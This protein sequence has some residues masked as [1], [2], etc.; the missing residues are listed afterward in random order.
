V[1]PGALDRR[2]PLIGGALA[3]LLALAWQSF[4]VHYNYGGNWT[5][6]FCTGGNLVQPPALDAEHIYRFAGS[7]GYDSQFYHYV[8]HD[9]LF[10]E[11][12]DRYIDAPRLR[13]RRILTPGLAY[14]AAGGQAG[15]IDAALVAVNL[16]FLFAG[17]EWS[18]R[19]AIEAHQ[20][21]AWGL[22]FLL[23]PAALISLDRLTV[24]LALT[25]LSVAF[26]LYVK[27]ERS[28][29]IYVVLLLAALTRETGLLLTAAYCASLLL[30]RRISRALLFA[31]SAAPALGWY[32]FVY[33]HTAAY[34]AEGWFT[35]VPLGA[36]VERMIHPAA[37]PFIPAVAWAAGI[38]DE[39][40]LAGMILAFVLALWRPGTRSSLPVALAAIFMA[41]SGLNLGT[42]F[43]EDV[44]SYGRV[45]SPLLVLVAL[46]TFST[47]SWVPALP[48]ALLV[49]RVCLP[50]AYQFVKAAQALF[51]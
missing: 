21:P 3:V 2:R 13:Y 31:T 48:A 28:R 18:C 8:A 30:E 43:W 23:A 19:Y 26:A 20:H 41:L 50:L 16:L 4:V 22:L 15:A 6:W 51:A 33:G 29:A 5:S 17:V 32:A 1:T 38:F 12:L 44:F 49:P 14:L 24:D 39:C 35:P 10:R 7:N 27:Q 46:Q 9:P 25:A 37:Y 40:A 42:P 11:R 34:R 45:F 36:I 47:R